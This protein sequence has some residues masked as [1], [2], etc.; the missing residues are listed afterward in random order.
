MPHDSRDLTHG[1]LPPRPEG[2]LRL[3]TFNT[4]HGAALDG[5]V[6]VERFARAVAYRDAAVLALAEVGR[7]S[8][9]SRRADRVA[10]AGTRARRLDVQG[11]TLAPVDLRGAEIDE[12]GGI[13][14]LRGSTIDSMQLA[15]L[16]A[17]FAHSLGITV[18]D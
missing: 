15:R 13:E 17:T 3:A 18:T 9:R 14:S 8:P 16:A 10:G 5:T 4:L 7:A 12:L 6:D 2:A 1:P 11:A